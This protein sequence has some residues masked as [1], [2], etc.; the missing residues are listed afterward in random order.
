M[1]GA[2]GPCSC[3]TCLCICRRAPADVTYRT[4]R[5]N[6]IERVWGANCEIR[7]DSQSRRDL[8]QSYQNQST[9]RAGV[10]YRLVETFPLVLVVIK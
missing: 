7:D 9:A 1:K 4:N 10:V 2:P 3:G 5:R 6:F 8:A